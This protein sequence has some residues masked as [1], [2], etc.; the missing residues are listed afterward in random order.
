MRGL[1]D[2]TLILAN[3]WDGSGT[4]LSISSVPNARVFY[5]A[6]SLPSYLLC[7]YT[8]ASL[9]GFRCAIVS[10]SLLSG[11]GLTVKIS[12]AGSG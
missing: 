10:V 9:C 5:G 4:T 11:Q 3:A 12:Q 6:S 8:T 7:T 2:S 1:K